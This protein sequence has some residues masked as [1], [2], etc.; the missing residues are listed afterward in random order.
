MELS[1]WVN[2]ARN[3]CWFSGYSWGVH[4][5]YLLLR[6]VADEKRAI[7][8]RTSPNFRP[9]VDNTVIEVKCHCFSDKGTI[10]LHYVRMKRAS[11]SAVSRKAAWLDPLRRRGKDYNPFA[12]TKEIRDEIRDTLH[13]DDATVSAIIRQANSAPGRDTGFVNKLILSGFVGLKG[14]IQPTADEQEGHLR[15]MLQQHAN[16]ERA[17]PIRIRGVD[18]R[19]GQT[20]QTN[21]PLNVVAEARCTINERGEP[22]II[23][24]TDKNHVGR[25][26]AHDFE[27]RTFPAW[28]REML[29]TIYAKL[30]KER[31]ES[32]VPE[33]RTATEDRDKTA[34]TTLPAG[35]LSYEESLAL[36]RELGLSDDPTDE[37]TEVQDTGEGASA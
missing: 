8:I 16:P 36:E 10:Q 33:A 32:M 11:I 1:D 4:D 27:H 30:A 22:N 34:A 19:Y 31:G 24:T 7:R 13:L 17:I 26:G 20:L 18:A 15:L 9:P 35:T 25:S 23:L 28:W 5:G 37:S 14:F 2:Q 3:I 21:M 6:Q 29:S 12:S